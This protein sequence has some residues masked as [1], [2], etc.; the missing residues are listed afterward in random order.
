MLI[1]PTGGYIWSYI[2]VALF[3]GFFAKREYDNKWLT[4]LRIF[5]VCVISVIIC[6]ALGTVQFMLV[7]K[8]D[9]IKALSLC[10]IPFIP[11][12]ALKAA[13]S[14][15]CGYEVRKRLS[16]AGLV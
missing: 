3:V 11:L 9:F 7:Q 4:I 16:K 5:I 2:F 14:A 8:T 10:V 13:V 12:D 15:Y 1:G 6:Y